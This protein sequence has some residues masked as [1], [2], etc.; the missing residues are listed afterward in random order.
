MRLVS[1]GSDLATVSHLTTRLPSYSLHT[2]SSF[3]LRCYI[4]MEYEHN[5]V[6]FIG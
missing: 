1:M 2:D 4:L 6:T 3:C 5:P